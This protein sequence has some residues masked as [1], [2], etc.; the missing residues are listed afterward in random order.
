MARAVESPLG[1]PSEETI[2]RSLES[3]NKQYDLII[4]MT[5]LLDLAHFSICIVVYV[6]NR[7]TTNSAA[8]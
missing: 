5:I 6:I 3:R 1:M 8:E 4:E 2:R 7:K